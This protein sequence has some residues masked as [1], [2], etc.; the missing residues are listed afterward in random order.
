MPLASINGSELH[1]DCHGH[2]EPLL[3][4]HGLGSSG[5]DWAFQ[6]PVLRER[7][8]VV[9]ADLR[10]SGLSGKPSEAYSIA[11]FAD[12]LWCL[13][14]H[15]AIDRSHLVGFSLGG[16]VALEMALQRPRQCHRLVLINALPSYRIDHWRKWLEAW[17][18]IA[19]VRVLGLPR[20]AS[21]IAKRLF[22]HP[23]QAPMQRRVVEVVGANAPAAYLRSVRALMNWCARERLDELESPTLLIAAEHDYTELDEKR[24]WA[25]RLRATL[26]VISGSRHGTPFDAIASTNACLLSFQQER[27]LP[28]A[29]SLRMDLAHEAPAS[30]PD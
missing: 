1:Y 12:D 24:D 23:H 4:I 29:D 5:A 21:M 20:T 13:L 11:G 28:A 22:P 2:G 18:Q 15:L 26:A 10:G 8:R 25:R 19:M 27:Q 6:I 3:L 16:A 14:D 17:T 30:A 7:F 9:V